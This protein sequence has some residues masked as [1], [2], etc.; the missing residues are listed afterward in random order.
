[1]S[2]HIFL[3]FKAKQSS[4]YIKANFDQQMNGWLLKTVSLM[5]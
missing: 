3:Y 2:F 5:R 1:M 4:N